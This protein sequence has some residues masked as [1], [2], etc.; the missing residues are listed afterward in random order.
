MFSMS[1]AGLRRWDGWIVRASKLSGRNKLIGW[2][3]LLFCAYRLGLPLLYAASLAS[4]PIL[5][6]PDPPPE[7]KNPARRAPP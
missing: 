3:L 6:L 2:L 1:S 4:L 7:E 5:L